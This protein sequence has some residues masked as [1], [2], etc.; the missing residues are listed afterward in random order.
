MSR[1]IPTMVTAA[2]VLGAVAVLALPPTTTAREGRRTTEMPTLVARATL[3]ADFIAPGP[4][5]GALATPAN[6]RVG[7]F[8]GQVIPGFSGMIEAGDGSFWAMP[9]NGFGTKANSADFLLRIYRIRPQWET[10]QGGAGTI[11]VGNFG[12]LRDPSRRIPFPI[13]NGATT[14]RLLTGADFD[15][16]S[17]VRLADGSFW[18]GEEF[19]P[20]LLHVDRTGRVLSAPVPFPDGKS[21]ANPY[22]APG[23]TPRIRSSRG[24]E[25]MAVSTNGRRLYPIV[26][27]SFADDPELRRRFIY[28]FDTIRGRYTGRTW[29]YEVDTDANVI[30]DAFT[31]RNNRLLL[32]ERDD[33]E[34]PASVIKR[35][36]EIDLRRTDEDGYVVKELVVDLLKVANPALIGTATTPGRYGVADSFSF[37][38]QSVE[39]VIALRDGRILVGNDNNYPGSNGRVPG[40]PDDTEMI[41]LDVPRVRERRSD[42]PLLIGHRGASGYRPEHTL[43]AYEL[44]ILQ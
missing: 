31:V 35:L 12:S 30:G 32:I 39:V 44:A 27:G 19:G 13:V 24:F 40:T 23:E 33:F 38:L 41:V 29:Q 22:L 17:I 21:P 4:P 11:E 16:E 26:E 36:Y 20:F 18:I 43:A 7:P 6:G 14:D 34:G 28:E 37:P 10:A 1:R 25:A 42:G 8:P 15:I 9:D 5:S 2:A 3:S